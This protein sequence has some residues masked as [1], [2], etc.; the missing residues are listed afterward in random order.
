[1]FI[2]LAVAFISSHVAACSC[3][4]GSFPLDQQQ[5]IIHSAKMKAG[6]GMWVTVE[7]KDIKIT[8]SYPTLWEK[9]NFSGFKGTSCETFGPNKESHFYCS[10]SFKAKYDVIVRDNKSLCIVNVIAKSNTRRVK[11]TAIKKKCESI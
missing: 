10:N 6:L 2:A 9:V 3:S 5:A 7:E 8:K 11:A 4:Q 1:M